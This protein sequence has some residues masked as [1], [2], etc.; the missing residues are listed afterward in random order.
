[1]QMTVKER[2]SK[3]YLMCSERVLL[4]HLLVFEDRNSVFNALAPRYF[5]HFTILPP[6]RAYLGESHISA[7]LFDVEAKK[8]LGRALFA[9]LTQEVI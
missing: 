4:L 3:S 6:S 8:G 7:L 5:C 9:E 2:Q 1:M